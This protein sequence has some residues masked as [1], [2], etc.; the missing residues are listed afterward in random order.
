[1]ASVAYGSVAALVSLASVLFYPI[2]IFR[3]PAAVALPVAIAV[4]GVLILKRHSHG[5]ACAGLSCV[6][7]CFFFGWRTVFNTLGALTAG[8]LWDVLLLLGFF[9]AV[10]SVPIGITVWC[11]RAETERQRREAD[12]ERTDD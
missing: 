5:P 10:Y 8:R 4:G 1:M 3:W 7:L 6:F 12:E 11:L 2:D 9:V